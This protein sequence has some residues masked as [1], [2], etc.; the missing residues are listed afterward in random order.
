MNNSKAIPKWMQR[1]IDLKVAPEVIAQ[2][3]EQRRLRDREWAL[4]NKDKKAM[5]KRAYRAKKKEGV[6][7]VKVGTVIKSTYRP[8][9]KEAPV[10]E[11]T[12]LNYRGKQT[13]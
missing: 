7:T 8:N 2:R 1:M 3:A 11:C 9:W 13:S 4:K 5:H 6:E 12:E 10:Y